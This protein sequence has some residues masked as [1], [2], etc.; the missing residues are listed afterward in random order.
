MS[1][2]MTSPRPLRARST[3]LSLLDL[4]RGESGSATIWQRSPDP[5]RQFCLA[6]RHGIL[7]PSVTREASLMEQWADFGAVVA[8]DITTFKRN[9]AISD[10]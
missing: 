2:L 1:P 6:Q 9:V 10:L 4:K 8:G 7:I 5:C 3:R